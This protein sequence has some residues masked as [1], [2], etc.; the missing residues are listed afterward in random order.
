[1]TP[2]L[3][4]LLIMRQTTEQSYDSDIQLAITVS[5]TDARKTSSSW[6]LW[7]I[8]WLESV[9]SRIRTEKEENDR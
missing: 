1:M 9:Q 5:C 2:V 4:L 7:Y 8:V 3:I 6:M